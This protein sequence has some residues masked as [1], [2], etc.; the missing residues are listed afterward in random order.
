VAASKLSQ[1]K[2]TPKLAAGI[3]H[4]IGVFRIVLKKNRHG[5]HPERQFSTSSVG[6]N[7]EDPSTNAAPKKKQKM[8]TDP[9]PVADVSL[10]DVFLDA[11][12]KSPF[13][14]SL[15]RAIWGVLEDDC[16]L[17]FLAS[18]AVSLSL[19]VAKSFVRD[20][21]Q[22]S[23]L[24][25]DFKRVVSFS[26]EFVLTAIKMMTKRHSAVPVSS[27]NVL[28]D[29]SFQHED[30]SDKIRRSEMIVE[31]KVLQLLHTLLL[32]VPSSSV[33]TQKEQHASTSQIV[34]FDQI[35][36]ESFC[37]ALLQ[38]AQ[39]LVKSQPHEICEDN[40]GDDNDAQAVRLAVLCVLHILDTS[41]HDCFSKQ[42]QQE[43]IS[44][45]L[46]G[47]CAAFQDKST[48]GAFL[49]TSETP[50]NWACVLRAER[51]VRFFAI[52]DDHLVSMLH[53]SLNVHLN[54]GSLGVLKESLDPYF[55]FV[56]L[57]QCLGHDHSVLLD[58]LST[59]TAKIVTTFLKYLIG[60][61]KLAVSNFAHFENAC[62]LHENHTL[63]SEDDAY[64]EEHDT[65]LVTGIGSVLAPGVEGG[66]ALASSHTSRC[67]QQ[68][69]TIDHVFSTLIRLR[70]TIERLFSKGLFPYNPA[71]LLHW[72]TVLEEMYEGR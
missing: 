50:R 37:M 20:A 62:T 60:F 42:D 23:I 47:L 41:D 3:S 40:N 54:L 52:Q 43:A 63:Y 36:G 8:A 6:Y 10:Q 51:R 58:L 70:M 66:E 46:D 2:G 18:V 72:L 5:A 28:V 14:E 32:A 9:C 39:S 57:L 33:G 4:C 22:T 45:G 49:K 69:P 26:E 27:A 35:R 21:E 71:P 16:S 56:S 64:F 12:L 7:G 61:L 67:M 59:S 13:R 24:P 30:I 48:A 44:H 25:C 11:F 15:A 55:S 29:D 53:V 17:T 1:L 38:F 34:F 19:D 68:P 65:H 31:V